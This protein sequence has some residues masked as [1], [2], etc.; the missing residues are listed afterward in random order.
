MLTHEV[1]LGLTLAIESPVVMLAALHQ[2]IYWVRGLVA[3]VLASGLTHPWA[4][5]V[6]GQLGPQDYGL[7]ILALE[8]TVCLIETL[9]LRLVMQASWHSMLALSVVANAASALTGVLLWN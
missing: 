6:S 1:A 9:I 7:W 2:R 5:W 3:G 8:I 4:W